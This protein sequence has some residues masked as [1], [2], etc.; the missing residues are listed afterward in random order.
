MRTKNEMSR[1]DE[2][3]D[4][5]DGLTTEELFATWQR[6]IA[7]CL[8]LQRESELVPDHLREKRRGRQGRTASLSLADLLDAERKIGAQNRRCRLAML[9]VDAT[10]SLRASYLAAGLTYEQAQSQIEQ[11]ER[12]RSR[13]VVERAKRLDRLR[14]LAALGER[15]GAIAY[16]SPAVA[17]DGLKRFLALYDN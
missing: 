15:S 12:D 17:L 1:L 11:L 9:E 13:E 14:E 7:E 4:S 6:A 5:L 2:S 16:D 3:R 10:V 8:E